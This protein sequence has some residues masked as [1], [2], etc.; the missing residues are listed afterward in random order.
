LGAVDTHADAVRSK[1]RDPPQDRGGNRYRSLHGHRLRKGVSLGPSAEAI[2]GPAQP[3]RIV[4]RAYSM[5]IGRRR[6]D[7]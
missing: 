5:L 6:L 2:L 3:I 1:P 7:M 4:P